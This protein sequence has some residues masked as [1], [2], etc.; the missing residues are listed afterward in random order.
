MIEK[1]LLEVLSQHVNPGDLRRSR[2]L[3]EVTSEANAE[4]RKIIVSYLDGNYG[5]LQEDK[6]V[7]AQ[8]MK[9]FSEL[10][11]ATA[12]ELAC[13]GLTVLN[14]EDRKHECEKFCDTVSELSRVYGEYG[15]FEVE[16][17][18]ARLLEKLQGI[19]EKRS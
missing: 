6:P 8:R 9:C 11:L 13:R 14:A 4:A 7:P 18:S 12:T 15:Y 3:A 1:E 5:E 17:M 19:L 10:C 16:D 2:K